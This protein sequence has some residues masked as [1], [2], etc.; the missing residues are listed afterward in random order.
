[1]KSFP[2][3]LKLLGKVPILTI[4][5]EQVTIMYELYILN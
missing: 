2:S 4:I 3:C 1:M 5:Y